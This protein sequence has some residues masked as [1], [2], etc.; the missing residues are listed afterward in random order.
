MSRMFQRVR[1]TRDEDKTKEQLIGELVEL[2]QQVAKLKAAD[3]EHQRAEAALKE[4]VDQLTN[5]LREVQEQL[6]RREKLAMLGRLAGG[7]AHELRNPLG[8]ISNAVYFLQMALPDADETIRKHLKIIHDEVRN[9]EVIISEFLDFSRLRLPEKEKVVVSELVAQTLEKRPP[10]EEV[11]VTTDVAPDLPLVYV[12]PWQ[13]GQVLVNL[14]TNAYQAM[15]EG[16]DL[17]IS[18]QV[19]EGWV[20]LSV[21]DTGCG[22]SQ[23]NMKKLFVPLFTTKSRGTGLGLVISRNLAEAN[24]GS[25]EVES[26]EGRGSTVRVLLPLFEE[27]EA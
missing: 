17:N 9:A 2:R 7:V 10:P 3:T 12:D 6:A 19:E 16:G 27:A 13:M 5:E 1:W 14:V 21:A 8:V 4:R 11:K 20:T 23:E 25:I 26:E 24:G 22:I 18:A 15:K